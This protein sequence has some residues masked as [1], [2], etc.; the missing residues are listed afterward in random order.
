[1]PES[2]DGAQ[3]QETTPNRN[4]LAIG[5]AVFGWLALAGMDAGSKTL[6]ANYPIVQILWF[7][8]LLLIIVAY[9]LMRRKGQHF[10]LRGSR[11]QFG[12]SFILVAEIVLA[13]YLFRHMALADVHAILAIAPILVTALSVPFLGE[14]VGIRRWAAVGVAFIGML[15]ILRPGFGVI[16]PMTLLA[17]LGALMFA[18]YQVL[19]RLVSRTDPPETSLFWVALVGLVGM[20]VAVPFFWQMPDNTTDAM[21]FFLVAFLGMVGHFC[22]IKSLQL[23]EASVLQ[24][25]SYMLLVGAVVMGYL[26]FGHLPDLATFIG[27]AIIV[28][29]GLYV[30]ARERKRAQ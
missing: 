10:Q 4:L 2:A 9:A 3:L 16:Q 28:L 19:T 14:K 22:L 26:V 8:F 6:V 17:L 30:F 27:A 7:R 24:P 12:R 13:I 29:S 25:Y 11:L 23:A 21:L 15:V 5:I 18:L 1:M 20:S